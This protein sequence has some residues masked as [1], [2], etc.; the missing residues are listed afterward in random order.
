V[1]RN[2]LAGSK[3]VVSISRDATVTFVEIGVLQSGDDPQSSVDSGCD[4]CK[5]IPEPKDTRIRQTSCA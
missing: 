3:T 4:S 5:V 2:T 1:L